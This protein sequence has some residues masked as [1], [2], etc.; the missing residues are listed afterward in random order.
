M[1]LHA[2][3]CPFDAFSFPF[4][5]ILMTDKKEQVLLVGLEYPNTMLNVTNLGDWDDEE[6]KAT[7]ATSLL[8]RIR[9]RRQAIQSG[10]LFLSCL[11]FFS[12]SLSF[13]KTLRAILL[14][15]RVVSTMKTRQSPNSHRKIS[16]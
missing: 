1:F 14:L 10:F 7:Q 4:R 16:F 12:I 3:P 8:S 2:F 6:L 5:S 11:L 15:L 13:H 9:G